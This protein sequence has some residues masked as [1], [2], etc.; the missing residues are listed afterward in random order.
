V[1][2]SSKPNRLIIY[3]V[4][5]I[6]DGTII[7]I[8]ADNVNVVNDNLEFYI[9]ETSGKVITTASYNL[10]DVVIIGIK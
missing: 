2:Q 10:D 5:F 1:E 3:K 7:K 4:K 9:Q 8:F 6:K